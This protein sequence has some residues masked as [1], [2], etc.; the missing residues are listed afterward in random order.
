MLH[1]GVIQYQDSVPV[2][3][4]ERSIKVEISNDEPGLEKHIDVSHSK[5]HHGSYEALHSVDRAQAHLLYFQDH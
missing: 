5:H 3:N 1:T 4:L 2:P